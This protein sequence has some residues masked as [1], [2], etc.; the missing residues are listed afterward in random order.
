MDDL[1]AQTVLPRFDGDAAQRAYEPL[2]ASAD[3]A[4]AW[5]KLRE[6]LGAIQPQF[7]QVIALSRDN[8]DFRAQSVLSGLEGPFATVQKDVHDLVR[9]NEAQ[10]A[11]ARADIARHDRSSMILLAALSAMS[12]GL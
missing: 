7:D 9:I 1:E 10:A 5:Q 8:E 6:D 3:E 4:A 2:I 11:Q 12:G